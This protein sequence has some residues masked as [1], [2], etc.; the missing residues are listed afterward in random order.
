M[1]E[2]NNNL[3]TTED[4]REHFPCVL[5]WW[6]VESFFK[7][8]ENEEKWSLKSV[9]TQWSENKKD[10]GSRFILNLFNQTNNIF[11]ECN[12]R[13]DGKKLNVKK[14]KFDVS[15]NESF[16]KGSYPNYEINLIDNKS[17]IKINLKYESISLPHWIGQD[18]TNGWLPLG[19]GFYRYGFI[20]INKISGYIEKNNKKLKIDGIGY[21]EHVW[22][23]LFYNNPF[24]NL[25]GFKKTIPF[26]LKIFRWWKENNKIKIPDS[27]VLS[28]ENN[29]FGYDWSWAVFDNG[30]SIFYGNILFWIMKGPAFGTLI[31][32]KDG[33]NYK[34]FVNLSFEYN[35]IQKSKNFDF[36]FPT[37]FEV[38][39]R[40][41]KEELKLHFK[42]K[43]DPIEFVSTFPKGKYYLG[44]VI[45]EAPGIVEGYYYDGKNKININGFAKIEPQRQV[46]MLGHN[47]LKIDFVKPPKGMG[48]SFN[49]NSNLLKKEIFTSIQ[50]FPRPK[51]KFKTEKI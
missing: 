23:D 48:I 30:W 40:D 37:E 28:T 21:L 38:F 19:A 32:T 29:P 36:V 35:K 13:I 45:C 41:K 20:P 31:F 3:W 34:E 7:T 6:A 8:V 11:T 17:N 15:F 46:S 49:L 51:I 4:E 25:I 44:L 2:K 12:I 18:I 14:N 47:M 22:G 16:I 5:E 33:Q 42:M 10:I 24:F 1:T 26:Y 43:S 50:L 39:A 9:F 27:L